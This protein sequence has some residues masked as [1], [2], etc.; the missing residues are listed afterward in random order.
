MTKSNQ[1]EKQFEGLLSLYLRQR[2]TKI[3]FNKI[4]PHLDEDSLSA[5]AEGSLT[6]TQ[7]APIL[8]HLIDCILCRR[9]TA[10]LA[11]LNNAL[12]DVSSNVETIEAGNWREFWNTLTES[13][14]RPYDSAVVA[15]EDKKVT[16][17]DSKNKSS[18]K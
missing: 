5:F 18:E 8:K 3:D 12:N 6:Q 15:H 4:Q 1:G 13:V 14:F 11:E 10:Q 16:E 7:A 17:E 9:V 2:Q